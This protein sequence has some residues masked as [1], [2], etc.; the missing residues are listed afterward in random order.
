MK[1]LSIPTSDMLTR[2]Y[3]N[4]TILDEDTYEYECI[5]ID[6]CPDNIDSIPRMYLAFYTSIDIFMWYYL[7]GFGFHEFDGSSAVLTRGHPENDEPE[8]VS[9][10]PVI[11]VVE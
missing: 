1:H 10:A 8:P 9:N 11:E 6:M 4:S 5:R 2:V 7:A 3:E